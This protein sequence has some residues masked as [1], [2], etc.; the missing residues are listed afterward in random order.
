M[1]ADWKTPSQRGAFSARPILTRILV[2]LKKPSMTRLLTFGIAGCLLLLGT[3]CHKQSSTPAVDPSVTLNAYITSSG[4]TD[5]TQKLALNN[6]VER[7][8]Q[9]SLWS[10]FIAIYPMVGGTAASDKWNLKD[11]RDMDDAFR[12]TF[13]GAPV[14]TDSGILFPTI[15][16]WADTHLADN[17]LPYNNNAISY[18]SMTQNQVSGYDMGCSDHLHPNNEFGI[19]HGSD[20]TEWFGYHGLRIEPAVTKGLFVVTATGGDVRRFDNGVLSGAKGAAP[21]KGYT[22]LPV[23]LGNAA[24]D[25]LCGQR[26]CAMATIGYGLS[27]QDV[28]TF[29]QI[30]QAFQADLKRH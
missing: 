29:Y 20:A 15:S 23:L 28:A 2:N 12:L 13:Q 14:F 4:I 10:K 30:A 6:F 11:P 24:Q 18:Y 27:D 7:L 1:K 22:N 25:T 3:S 5:S 26:V 8:N 21:V 17:R 19:F 9:A 16:D